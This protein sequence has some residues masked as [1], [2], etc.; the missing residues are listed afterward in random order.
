MTAVPPILRGNPHHLLVYCNVDRGSNSK[1]C[2]LF[3]Q[4]Q[5]SLFEHLLL[6]SR[7]DY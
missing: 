5:P 7:S 2:R 4:G 1:G 6:F 3:H